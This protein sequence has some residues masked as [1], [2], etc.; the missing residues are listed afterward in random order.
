[1]TTLVPPGERPPES[2]VPRYFRMA[3]RPRRWL[4]IALYVVWAVIGV[5][6]STGTAF[7]LFVDSAID[8]AHPDTEAFRVALGA[9]DPVLPGRPINILLMGS[10][11]RPKDGDRGAATR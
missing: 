8:A 11:K 7:V 10:D 2:T 6:V 5:A 3:R 1:M 4:G 9:T